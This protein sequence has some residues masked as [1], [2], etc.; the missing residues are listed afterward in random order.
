VKVTT[1]DFRHASQPSGS[2]VQIPKDRNQWA[3]V[4]VIIG[5]V[6]HPWKGY[7]GVVES[8]LYGQKTS[9]GMRVQVRLTHNDPTSPFRVITV[10]YD[11]LVHA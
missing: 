7:M 1:P 10:D 8:V 9:S 2:N 4:P 5:K 6:G 11:H 3:G